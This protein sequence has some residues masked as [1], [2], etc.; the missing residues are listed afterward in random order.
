[1]GG[2]GGH[3]GNS[4]SG[5]IKGN[6]CG[7]NG[8]TM[9]VVQLNFLN[10]LQELVEVV[11][12]VVAVPIRSGS[13]TDGSLGQGVSGMAGGGG[14]YYGGGGASTHSSY[15]YFTLAEGSSWAGGAE[16]LQL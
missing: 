2:E 6:C 12:Q 1:M 8:L 16:P 3:A 10:T 7:G 9:L 11:V 14:G 5:N 13:T 15:T 4:S